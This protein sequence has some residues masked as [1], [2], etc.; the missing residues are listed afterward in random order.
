LKIFLNHSLQI[1]D[2]QPDCSRK[3][4]RLSNCHAFML[5]CYDF[6]HIM[7]R[8]YAVTIGR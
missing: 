1:I 3:T 2:Q 4:V 8:E 7:A 6:L 5:T